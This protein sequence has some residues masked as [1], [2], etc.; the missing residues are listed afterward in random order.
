MARSLRVLARL[1]A[2]PGLVLPLAVAVPPAAAVTIPT[3]TAVRAAHHPGYDRLVLQFSGALPTATAAWKPYIVN[4]ETGSRVAVAGHAFA[5]ISMTPAQGHT[6]TGHVTLPRRVTFALPNL[7]QLVVTEDFEAHVSIGLG[8]QR[9]TALHVQRLT[10]PSRV[11]IDVTSAWPTTNVKDYFLHV[12]SFTVGRVPYIR[13]VNRP[14]AAGGVARQALER[15]F[16][17]PTPAERAAG[18]TFLASGATG[19]SSLSISQGVARVRLTGNCR[20]GGATS[21]A[22]LIV[23]TLKQFAS[24]R[25]VKIYDRLGR[26]GT[27]SGHV[28]SLPA[29]LEP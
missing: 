2:G 29:C 11:V 5:L 7:T 22:N 28:D 1:L 27:P 19:F 21:V 14:V 17:G 8:L 3:V 26:T 23:P 15:L 12:P 20:G 10:S 9:H 16:A 18:L 25:W 6:D 4:P 24:V 13:A